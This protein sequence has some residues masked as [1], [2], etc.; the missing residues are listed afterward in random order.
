[1]QRTFRVFKITAW[2]SG[3]KEVAVKV[4][5]YV[6]KILEMFPSFSAVI[7]APRIM[8]T[9]I[10]ITAYFPEGGRESAFCWKRE[11]KKPSVL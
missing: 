11:K 5:M 8:S 1:M 10:I 3:Q 4:Q 2:N 9:I 7:F 6:L